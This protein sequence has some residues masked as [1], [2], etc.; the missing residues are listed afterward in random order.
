MRSTLEE[1]SNTIGAGENQLHFAA[2]CRVLP[3]EVR[4]VEGDRAVHSRQVRGT[5]QTT[6]W[7]KREEYMVGRPSH[8]MPEFLIAFRIEGFGDV[9]V[10]ADAD[11]DGDAESSRG[12]PGNSRRLSMRILTQATAD[13]L[14][15]MAINPVI[16]SQCLCF[17]FSLQR[18]SRTRRRQPPIF[19]STAL[20][21][22]ERLGKRVR[23]RQFDKP[24]YKS[25]TQHV[26]F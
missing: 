13:W 1:L 6:Y 9:D 7:P 10:D 17:Q 8:V 11:A 22:V 26:S 3:G 20:K 2:L 23:Q 21:E 14:Y 12:E 16:A 25:S 19:P 4:V 15:Y 18:W 5:P 24:S